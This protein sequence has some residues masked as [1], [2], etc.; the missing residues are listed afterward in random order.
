MTVEG[1]SD[2][3]ESVGG[4]ENFTRI[5]AEATGDHFISYGIDRSRLKI[6]SILMTGEEKD[7]E[8]GAAGS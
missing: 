1:H 4:N 8:A 2:N 6:V 5:R 3:R 7:R